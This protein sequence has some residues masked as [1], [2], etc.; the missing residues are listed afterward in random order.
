MKITK[1]TI[2]GL[3]NINA[4]VTLSVNVVLGCAV[5]IASGAQINF[6]ADSSASSFSTLLANT[7]GLKV[8]H[9]PFIFIYLFIIID[10]HKRRYNRWCH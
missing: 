10:F 6:A 9:S 8:Y 7:P 3:L 5:Q 2:T 1:I 4:N